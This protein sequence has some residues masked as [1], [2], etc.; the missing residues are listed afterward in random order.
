MATLDL[1]VWRGRRAIPIFPI[2]TPVILDF[3]DYDH[4]EMQ[5]FY[6]LEKHH[7]A[8]V[9]VRSVI[10]ATL[11]FALAACASAGSRVTPVTS[12]ATS[13]VTSSAPPSAAS[14]SVATPG[15]RIVSPAA[16]GDVTMPQMLDR[17]SRSDVVFFGEQHDDPETHRSEAEVLDAIGRLGRPV[18]LSLEMFE[19]DV[20]PVI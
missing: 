11:A 3:R 15:Y 4:T 18:V 1:R 6:S 7:R 8:F 20:Q 13:S 5:A 16:R 9:N 17:L 12:P 19:R 10:V 2:G 14:I